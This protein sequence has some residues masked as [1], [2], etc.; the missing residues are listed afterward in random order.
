MA[1][2]AVSVSLLAASPAAALDHETPPAPENLRLVIS[3]QGFVDRLAWDP[4][5][6]TSEPTRYDVHYRFANQDASGDD[7]FMSTRDTFLEGSGAFG[8]FVEC[9]PRH[10]PDEEWLVWMT[11]QTAD[12]RSAPSNQISMCFP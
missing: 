12:G 5:S 7:V 9:G 6:H 8:R 10:R 2:T 3:E 4:P 1:I 11:Y